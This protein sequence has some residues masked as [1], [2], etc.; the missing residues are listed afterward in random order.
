MKIIPLLGF[1]VGLAVAPVAQ[2]QFYDRGPFVQD[3]TRGIEWLRC[4]VGQRWNAD[5]R[6]CDGKIIKISQ[7]NMIQVIDQANDQLG[8]GWRLPTREELQSLLCDDCTPPLI[9]QTIFPGTTPEAYWTGDK[10][11]FSSKNHWSVNFMTGHSYSRFFN[12][13]EL[14]VR[15]VRDRG[16]DAR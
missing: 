8:P 14:P 4:S 3:L 12:F 15:L 2:G 5:T 11:F 10:V 6:Q 1:L 9:D 13:Q 16:L 7:D